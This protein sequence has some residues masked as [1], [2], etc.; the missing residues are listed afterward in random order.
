MLH[1][2]RAPQLAI[3]SSRCHATFVLDVLYRPGMYW[4]CEITLQSGEL[5]SPRGVQSCLDVSS[6]KLRQRKINIVM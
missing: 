6:A 3:G 4:T 2:K 1:A 5:V